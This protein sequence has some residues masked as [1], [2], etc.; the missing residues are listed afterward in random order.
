MN[1][2]EHHKRSLLKAITFRVLATTAEL[3][4]TFMITHRY[5]IT[6]G[7]VVA[8]DTATTLLYYFH[9]RLWNRIKWGRQ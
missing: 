4:V 1:F 6:I 2:Y 5:D 9:E 7:L 3:L 8:T